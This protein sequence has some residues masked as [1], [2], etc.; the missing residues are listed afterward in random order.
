LLLLLGCRAERS[1]SLPTP[2]EPPASAEERAD[3][4]LAKEGFCDFNSGDRQV[5]ERAIR[6]VASR[7][8]QAVPDLVLILRTKQDKIKS[9]NWRLRVSAAT[10]L[11]QVGEAALA[12]MI[13]LLDSREGDVAMLVAREAFPRLGAAGVPALVKYIQNPAKAG[14]RGH[15]EA[16]KA[17]G[18]MGPD[19]RVAVP[20]LVERL[21]RGAPAERRLAAW[22]LAQI[23]PDAKPAVAALI[24][25]LED[26]AVGGWA[27]VALG[28]IGPEAAEA[29]QPLLRIANDPGHPD[30]RD[31][32]FALAE[33]RGKPS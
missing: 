18:Q 4:V 5:R 27:C 31:A 12:T 10:A 15:K 3:A 16:F 19:A 8:Q 1:G 11:G 17:L 9:E 32:E 7:G 21:R 6:A 30:K 23:G 28:K 14:T 29:V 33:I 25:A 22:T 2:K 24:Q 26:R 13:E 20:A